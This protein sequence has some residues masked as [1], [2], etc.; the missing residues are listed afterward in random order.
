MPSLPDGPAPANSLGFLRWLVC[1]LLL[2]ATAVNYM[3][4]VALNQTSKEIIDAYGFNKASWGQVEMAFSI[5]FGVGTLATGWFVDRVGVYWLYPAL[6]VGWSMAGFF[7]GS[8]TGFYSLVAIR[9]L[10]GLFEAGNWPC[11]IRTT[12]QVL[13]PAERPFG[14]A[15]FQSGTGIGSTITPFIVLICGVYFGRDDPDVWRWPF[16]VIG[17]IGLG[18]V[19]LWF[20]I[21]PRATLHHVPYRSAAGPEPFKT[22]LADRRFWLLVA[23][24]IGVNTAWHTFR[25]W[26]PLY[27]REARGFT[28][29][30]LQFFSVFYYVASDVG[31]WVVGLGTMLLARVGVEVHRSRLVSYFLC[32][33]LLLS[34]FAVFV[35]DG[36][37]IEMAF[38][39]YGFGALG[40]FSI[41]FTLTQELSAVHQG[42]VVGSL[43]FINAMYLAAMYPIQGLWI[44]WVRSYDYLLALAGLPAAFAFVGVLLFWNRPKKVPLDSPPS[45]VLL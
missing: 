17:V 43:G 32:V 40:L 6:V 12:R 41:Y 4:R 28:K 18:W 14:N 44:D 11:G 8:I 31:I 29:E 1:G 7:T 9:F 22:V 23:V 33:C 13:S 10:L 35:G 39:A 26:M 27:L 38:L 21:V 36:R 2:L 16:R 45:D 15:L 25:V 42:K 24:V 37:V 30:E 5:A 20:L 19:S 34:A 3:D